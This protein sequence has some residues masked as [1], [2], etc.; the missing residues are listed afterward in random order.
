MLSH[1]DSRMVANPHTGIL[2]HPLAAG[3]KLQ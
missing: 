2:P 1:V 3:K